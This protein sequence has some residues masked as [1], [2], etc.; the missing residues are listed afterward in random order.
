MQCREL[1]FP[2]PKNLTYSGRTLM[3]LPHTLLKEDP[4]IYESSDTPLAFCWH[5]HSSLE[6]NKYCH[7]KEYRKRLYFNKQFLLF[8][9]LFESLKIVVINMVTILII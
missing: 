1:C 6:I 2:F 9:T 5:Q 8:L 4:K 7:I 3:G